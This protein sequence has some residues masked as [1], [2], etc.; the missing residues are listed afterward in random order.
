[1][2]EMVKWNFIKQSNYNVNNKP[3]EKRSSNGKRF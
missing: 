1:M 2:P 3:T